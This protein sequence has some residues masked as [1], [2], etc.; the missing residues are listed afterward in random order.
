MG[1][2]GGMNLYGFVG[3]GAI[4]KIDHMG[5]LAT[6]VERIADG[7]NTR[8]SLKVPVAFILR[9]CR[10]DE[11]WVFGNVQRLRQMMSHAEKKWSGRFPKPRGGFWE[12]KV[13]FEMVERK[14]T[15]YA[16]DDL[17]PE[18]HA[19]ANGYNLVIIDASCNEDARVG[20]H[21]PDLFGK[22]LWNIMTLCVN[23][24]ADHELEKTF[25]HEVGH[26]LGHSDAYVGTGYVADFKGNLMERG[27]EVNYKN[28]EH[29]F[30]GS[31]VG[32]EKSSFGFD[33]LGHW[34]RSSISPDALLKAIRQE[35]FE[36]ANSEKNNPGA[37]DD[38]ARGNGGDFEGYVKF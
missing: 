15:G 33:Y 20:N 16:T 9:A 31:S 28:F 21:R 11:D 2:N 22:K 4:Q 10:N 23:K 24:D 34:T 25:S 3:N 26:F 19:T 7:A 30:N 8:V 37:W 36:R 12:V 38:Y 17:T 35:G 13:E 6:D 1:E 5:L 32:G 27:F 18:A 14:L 29:L